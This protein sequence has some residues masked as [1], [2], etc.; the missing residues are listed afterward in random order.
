MQDL[1]KFYI[2]IL[3]FNFFFLNEKKAKRYESWYRPWLLVVL[4]LIS[5]VFY[6]IV[7]SRLF[8]I[9]SDVK[10]FRLELLFCIGVSLLWVEVKLLLF[11]FKLDSKILPLLKK[12]NMDRVMER[13]KG[14]ANYLLW[15]YIID[16]FKIR[17]RNGYKFF[18]Y[19]FWVAIIIIG[20]SNIWSSFAYGFFVFAQPTLLS[21]LAI[22]IFLEWL[23]YFNWKT[24]IEVIKENGEQNIQNDSD[25][26]KLYNRYINKENGF[27]E[28]FISGYYSSVV[29][30]KESSLQQKESYLK[31]YIN[32]INIE[33]NDLII[34]SDNFTDLVPEM[35]ELLISTIE[36]GGNILLL[37]DIADHNTY[38][39]S[40]VG[41]A[42]DNA[43]PHTLVELFSVYLQQILNHKAPSAENLTD[44]GFYSKKNINGLSKR[45][46]ICT[47]EDALSKELIHS[48]WMKE[49]DLLLVFQ[50]ND[51]MANNLG[52]KRQ[53]SLWLKQQNKNFKSIFFKNY[54]AGGDE[55]TSVTWISSRDV[56]EVNVQNIQT[57]KK[58]YYINF[59]YE[60]CVNNL[61]KILIGNANE[62]DLAPGIELA[63]FPI[64]EKI[65]HIHFFEGYNLDYI[66]S[67]N[68]LEGLQKSFKNGN[69]DATDPNNYFERVDQ[70]LLL[71]SIFVNNLP[72]I[73]HPLDQVNCNDKHVS[74]IF[75][76]INNAPKLYQKY[77][78]LGKDESFICIVSKPHLMREYFAENIYFFSASTIEPLELQ[79]SKSKINLCLEL[80]NLLINEQI[81][82]EFIKGLINLH[83]IDQENKS[84]IEFIQ[85][86]FGQYL[87]LDLSRNAIL[88]SESQY[89]FK[90]GEY[91]YLNSLSMD[92]H[93]LEVN[94]IFEYLKHVNIKDSSGNL[95][96]EIPKYLL[97]QN[98]LPQQNI[99]IDG[100]SYEY[101]QY[102]ET[103]KELVLKTRPTDNFSFYK[104]EAVIHASERAKVEVVES[105]D[106][107][108]VFIDGK[109]HRFSSE[110]LERE[111]EIYYENYYQFN[112]FYNSPLSKFQTPK[113]ISLS[114]FDNLIEDS[115]R[116]Y[117]TRYLQFQ[118][119]VSERFVDR[120]GELTTRIHHLLYE[121]LPILFP[122]RSQYLLVASNNNLDTEHRKLVPW[123]FPE[124]NFEFTA[125]NCIELYIL[126]DS[127]SDLGILKPIQ[128]FFTKKILTELYFYLRWVNDQKSTQAPQHFIG[129]HNNKYFKDKL[130]FLKYGLEDNLV[131]WD[132]DFLI[133]FLESSK[134]FDIT[135][136][137]TG[138]DTMGNK[139]NVDPRSSDAV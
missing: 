5:L 129:E 1:W 25:F 132:I 55:A 80:L 124:N 115:K 47:T 137:G 26:Y 90:D 17:F 79:L 73:L 66:Q 110:I 57:A 86:L 91:Y 58:N 51:A 3:I 54:S 130:A 11:I 4:I 38:S 41:I 33:N 104:P 106:N 102:S 24:P 36:R 133:K 88:K 122:R 101:I 85:S 107:M 121:F 50:F 12:Y 128:N 93:K 45:I 89:V 48:D 29:E 21:L 75:D 78:H 49:M 43:K 31:K 127:F 15:P 7:A 52:V 64:M 136:I 68:K 8:S 97:F 70:T 62:F 67:K 72:F 10:P 32:R 69:G 99:I 35:I 125:S 92:R 39:P 18:K 112:R 117:N 16:N 126:E 63:V 131:K 109:A 116:K 23:V 22:P 81:D 42:L 65:N 83:S 105:M 28:S 119:E 20:L 13:K 98:F 2:V 94:D 114:G 134:L 46:L 120:L 138:Y 108:G 60:Y 37:A 111:I 74:V 44:I 103:N 96:M 82:M 84:I 87:F 135:A 6:N 27:Y 40:A 139:S 14:Y 71:K 123:V 100:I 53:L 19:L 34:G 61:N 30:E 76:S 113:L 95:I 9:F 118:W 59:A 77:M 56:P